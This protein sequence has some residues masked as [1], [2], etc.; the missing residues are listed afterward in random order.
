MWTLFAAEALSI[1]LPGWQASPRPFDPK[2]D[3]DT[4]AFCRTA[5][6]RLE[7]LAARVRDRETRTGGV[8]QA[9]RGSQRIAPF[10]A[11]AGEESVN[12]VLADNQ[13]PILVILFM[14][15]SNAQQEDSR[16]D[17]HVVEARV[18]RDIATRC[19]LQLSAWHA[20]EIDA[21]P[22]SV[23]ATGSAEFRLNDKT[24]S[25]TF[26]DPATAAL[27]RAACDGDAAAV[28][29]AAQAGGQ[30]NANGL[31][32]MT[33]LVWAIACENV[34]GM[35]A[36]LDAGANPNEPIRDAGSA[37][38]V[39]ATYRNPDLLRD[40]LRHGGNADAR[41]QRDSA[42]STAFRLGVHSGDFTNYETLLAAGADIN[43]R[44]NGDRD[45]IVDYM[46]IYRR[47]Q[48]VYRLLQRGYTGDL[49]KLGRSVTM[50]E[51]NLSGITAD[52][53]PWIMRVK[54][55]LVERGVRFPVPGLMTLERDARGFY[56]Q[57]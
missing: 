33:P 24:A 30:P 23:A 41:D 9:F 53:H 21:V 18:Y 56:I 16:T 14:A 46:T 57:R 2:T 38:L 29:R 5:Y 48:E 50:D 3:V 1:L 11:A 26:A 17:P 45:T 36:L 6:S 37:V 7:P 15:V 55:F 34:T 25:E 10:V 51:A 31:R 43:L 27:T 8:V 20:P 4:I 28:R 52:V 39:A 49:V 22:P 54:A 44:F 32:G 12:A 13:S 47:Y 35:S 40:L 42:L 19:D